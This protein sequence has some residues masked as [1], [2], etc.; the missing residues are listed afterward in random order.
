MAPSRRLSNG[1][2]PLVNKQSQITAF[3]TPGKST[4]SV[5]PS[6]APP[7]QQN[8]KSTPPN[9]K[10][11]PPKP[12]SSDSKKP[13]LVIGSH[14]HQS[15]STPT[16]NLSSIKTPESGKRLYGESVVRKRIRVYWPVDKK[17]Y[18]GFVK[19]F[20]SLSGKH[21]I[22]YDDSEEEELYLEKEKIEWAAEEEKTKFRRLKRNLASENVVLDVVEKEEVKS[23]L[24]RGLKMVVVEDDEE[25]EGGS[26]GDDSEDE[27]WGKNVEK[28]II[29]D[30]M[31]E[32]D[33][34]EEEVDEEVESKSKR[35]CNS[36]PRKRKKLDAEKLGSDKKCKTEGNIGKAVSKISQNGNGSGLFGLSVNL[37]REHFIPNTDNVL[38]GDIAE[39]FGNLEVEKFCFLGKDRRDAKRR[40]PGD[41]DYDPNTLYL[42]PDFVNNLTGGQRQ[43][44]EFKAKHMDKVL[45][46][47]MGKFYELYE[48]DAHIGTKELDLQYMRG[49]QPHCGFPEKNFSMNAEKL[50]RKGYCVL[51]VE[52]TETPDQLE[53]RRKKGSKDKVVK[54][55]I[56]AVVTKGTLIEG[57][58]L[59]INPDA[60]YMISITEGFMASENQK[61]VLAIGVCIVDVSTS[62]FMLGQFADDSERNSL[63]SL[64]SEL[65]PVEIIKPAKLLS[66]GSE[67]VLLT[68]TRSPLVNELVPLLEFWSAEKTVTEVR[69]I[70]RRR[71]DQ[72]VTLKKSIEDS[73]TNIEDGGL[74]DLPDVISELVNDGERGS[75]AVSAFGGC[76]SYLRKAF[77]D[78]S[79]LKCAKFELLPCSRFRDIHQKPYMILDAAAIESLEL[80]ENTRDGSSTG[81][82]YG[83]LN[84]CVTS[85]GKRMLKNWL[86]RPLYLAE[87]IR[88]R[89]DA[90]AGL[91]G[92]ALP[93]VLEFR[94]ELSK[95]PDMERL[96]GRIFSRSEANGR[97]ANKVILYED[98]AK[99]QLQEFISALRGCELMARACSSLS[100][101]LENVESSLLKRL[102]TPGKD[103]PDLSQ[104]LNHFKEAFYWTEAGQSGRII[105]HVGADTEY[106]FA[107]EVVKEIESK[108]ERHREEQQKVIQ[109][110]SIKYVIVGKDTYLLEI[111]E[112]LQG[113]VPQNYE[114]RSSKKGVMRYW[115]PDIKK[116]LGELSQAESEKESKLKC[117][118]QRLIGC[119]CE[120]HIRWRQLVSATAE[121]DVL[122]SLAIVSDYYEG[123]ICR[124]TILDSPS[125]CEVP[126]LCGKSL[127][128][129][130]LTS[131]SLG[132]GAFVPNDVNLGGPGCPSF[133]LLTGPNMGGKSTLIRQICIAVILAQLGA[134]VPAEHFEIS[135]VDR[136]FVRMGAKDHIMSGQSTFL[137]ELSETASMLS[138]ATSKS[139][140]ALD[141]LGRGTSTSDG[142]A[143]AES[144]L[145]HFVHKVYCRGLFSTHYH[146][147]AVD[148]ERDPQVALCHM[149]CRVGKENGGVEEVT[150]LYKLTPGACPKSYGVNVARLAGTPDS[151]LQKAA[152]MSREFERVYGKKKLKPTGSKEELSSSNKDEKIASLIKELGHFLAKSSCLGDSEVKGM[153]SLI[154]LQQTGRRLLLQE[155]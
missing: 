37:E 113:R 53:L 75:Y 35:G 98:E 136:I 17:W 119:F 21:L 24:R 123:P 132:K 32:L 126:R 20:D 33:L 77:L 73:G 39:R 44:W 139:L 42:P 138:S 102:L 105:P 109:D 31:E 41:V 72:P 18:D 48:M 34:V 104:V 96:L 1:R 13:L 97:N 43:W 76:L 25:E 92:D 118:L 103:L 52:Q 58:M 64:L 63:C 106:D 27:D 89:Q 87:S 8:P 47:K 114:L 19:S 70:Y 28:E 133:I 7:F 62:R 137:T 2:S 152:A 45:F 129:P 95:L 66:S 110:A 71:K 14:D 85:F 29:D 40:R 46:F 9:P 69:S 144:V 120:H 141:E 54:R 125:S 99:R 68:H 142:Q 108:L 80:F 147:L 112:S 81:T 143:I 134:D 88:E 101:K 90:V 115:T 91:R 153:S 5:S 131:D 82:L 146:R 111:P 130:V 84:Q 59:T 49:E 67:K 50:A 149:G 36:E 65:R 55:E 23:R 86:V 128:H 140:V 15:P 3:F 83:Q 145:D 121:L 11:I 117:I 150:F 30:E 38:T 6:S 51:V 154:E 124:P 78:Q 74:N 94:K 79:L 122:I 57:E 148:Y 16:S 10:Y 100:T 135:P 61:D 26:G 107:C 155:N 93:H 151:V 127:G 12:K 22:Q 60:S 4:T 56:C 116:L